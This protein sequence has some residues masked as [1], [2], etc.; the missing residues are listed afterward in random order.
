[1]QPPSHQLAAPQE[2]HQPTT[3]SPSITSSSPMTGRRASLRRQI[4][5]TSSHQCPTPPPLKWNCHQP[6]FQKFPPPLVYSISHD[7]VPEGTGS[8]KPLAALLAA[9]DHMATTPPNP[10]KA[11]QTA[12][13]PSQ[14]HHWH[15]VF[16]PTP[17]FVANPGG[18]AVEAPSKLPYGHLAVVAAPSPSPLSRSVAVPLRRTVARE[19]TPKPQYGEEWLPTTPA[20]TIAPLSSP[21]MTG[22]VIQGAPTTPSSL[23]HSE[24]PATPTKAPRVK[25]EANQQDEIAFVAAKKLRTRENSV[26]S[27]HHEVDN[28][29]DDYSSKRKRTSVQYVTPATVSTETTTTPSSRRLSKRNQA[30]KFQC[31]WSGCGKCFTTSGHLARHARIHTGVFPYKC[32]VEDCNKRFTRQDNMI[33]HYR[34]HVGSCNAVAVALPKRSTATL[35]TESPPATPPASSAVPDVPV[36]ASDGLVQLFNRP[37][38]A[39]EFWLAVRS[40]A[41]TASTSSKPAP[42]KEENRH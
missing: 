7:G 35:Q 40:S 4:S 23:L 19:S 14:L 30:G 13:T 2:P 29:A 18:L 38:Q 8:G 3:A 20:S 16:R 37:Q 26:S 25:A 17:F 5:L 21:P 27:P 6:P 1:M 34:S 33:Q 32:L 28:E 36:I 9:I 31:E 15:P 10:E 22:F 42:A 12:Q 24:S 11:T 39:A 41:A